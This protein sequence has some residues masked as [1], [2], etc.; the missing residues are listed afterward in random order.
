MSKIVEEITE[1]KKVQIEC[2]NL[3]VICI[4]IQILLSHLPPS[5]RAVIVSLWLCRLTDAPHAS[6][7]SLS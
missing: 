5:A 6:S 4:Y 7:L 1:K 2:L 3:E